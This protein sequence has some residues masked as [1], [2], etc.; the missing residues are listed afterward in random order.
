[1]RC[2]WFALGIVCKEY[3]SACQFHLSKWEMAC[4]DAALKES[5]MEEEQQDIPQALQIGAWRAWIVCFRVCR[6]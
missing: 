1:M 4:A 2:L 5:N 6:E 3:L